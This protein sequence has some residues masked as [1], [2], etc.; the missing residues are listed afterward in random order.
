MISSVTFIAV[1]ILEESIQWDSDQVNL[2]FL[3]SIEKDNPT[4][5]KLWYY[6]SFLI[7][8]K[9]ALQK[10]VQ[11]PTYDNLLSVIYHV[12]KDLF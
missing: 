5:Y 2:V 10:I 4:A 12:Y 3:V 11:L 9:A 7:S 8:N 1:A 6:L